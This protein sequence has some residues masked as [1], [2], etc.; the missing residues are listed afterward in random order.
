MQQKTT[1]LFLSLVKGSHIV[2]PQIFGKIQPPPEYIY[3]VHTHEI[4]ESYDISMAPPYLKEEIMGTRN[5]LY[6]INEMVYNELK[7][8]KIED[9]TIIKT[10]SDI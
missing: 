1:V 2:L 5:A 9:I 8:T 4:D 3:L 7:C 10:D 6:K